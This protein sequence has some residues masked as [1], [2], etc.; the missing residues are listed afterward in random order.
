MLRSNSQSLGNRVVSLEEEKEGC[1]GKDFAE[2][3]G[4][5]PG[6]K[7][8]VVNASRWDFQNSHSRLGSVY[9]GHI[10]GGGGETYNSPP[11][12]CQIVSSKSFFRPGQWIT[13]ILRKLVTDNKHRKL[14]VIK[15]SKG[16]KFMPKI[17]QKEWRPGSARTRWGILCALPDLLAAMGAYF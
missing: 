12:G 9:S 3:E 4:F 2:N 10:F 11:N 13:N 8:W 1:G 16:C 15:R 6:M 7:E 5:K 14:F 17:Q